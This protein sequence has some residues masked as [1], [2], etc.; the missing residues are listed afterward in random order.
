MRFLLSSSNVRAQKSVS[1]TGSTTLGV[2]KS[3]ARSAERKRTG[4]AVLS[5]FGTARRSNA[6]AS[7][8]GDASA[9][10]VAAAPVPRRVEQDAELVVRPHRCRVNLRKQSLPRQLLQKPKRHPPLQRKRQAFCSDDRGRFP[11][12]Y[13]SRFRSCWTSKLTDAGSELS[14][15]VNNLRLGIANPRNS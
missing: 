12:E 9:N 11:T 8:A 15:G 7:T 4:C 6:T 13:S 10:S 2:S 1:W 3:N 5:I 14:H